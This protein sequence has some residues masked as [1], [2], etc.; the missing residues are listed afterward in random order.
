MANYNESNV[1]GTMYQRCKQVVIN[2]PY[3]G[4]PMILMQEESVVLVGDEVIYKPLPGLSFAFDQN[5]VI[6]MIN[7][8]T[9][10]AVDGATMTGGEV[11]AAIYSYYIKKATERDA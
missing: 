8:V 7:P 3:A 2:N 4:T 10:E 5:E 11:Y 6:P 9:G 1:A